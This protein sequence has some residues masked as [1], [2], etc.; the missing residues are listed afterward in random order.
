[1]QTRV[2]PLLERLTDRTLTAREKRKS[3]LGSQTHCNT[4]GQFDNAIG[5]QDEHFN[6]SLFACSRHSLHSFSESGENSL[7]GI[8]PTVFLQDLA[9]GMRPRT[10]CFT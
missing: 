3:I 1:M 7:S 5:I 6:K 8:A 2:I 4:V 9:G 10:S